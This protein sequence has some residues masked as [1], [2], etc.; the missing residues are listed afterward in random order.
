MA[1]S[2]ILRI[3]PRK[4]F[5]NKDLCV[6]YS[7]IRSYA[8]EFRAN[9]A[10]S[11]RGGCTASACKEGARVSS[12]VFFQRTK[13]RFSKSQIAFQKTKSRCKE[14]IALGAWFALFLW[15]GFMVGLFGRLSQGLLR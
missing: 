12:L 5:R 4:V 7:G 14:R 1:K 13:S 6:M 8:P 10:L 15:L 3:F 9:C 11:A 2:A